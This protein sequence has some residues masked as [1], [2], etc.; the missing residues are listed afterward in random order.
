M[1]DKYDLKFLNEC[2]ANNEG[3]LTWKIR[4]LHH[5]TSQ[6]KCDAFNTRWAGKPAGNKGKRGY[7]RFT[8]AGKYYY[9]HRVV[10]LLVNGHLPDEIDHIDGNPTNNKPCNLRVAVHAENMQNKKVMQGSSKYK[11]VSWAKDKGKWRVYCTDE[12]RGKT[13]NGRNRQRYVGQSSCEIEAARMYDKAAEELY[14]EFAWL[15]KDHFEE[16]RDE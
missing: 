6:S 2:V 14:G 8:A 7:L 15:N 11:G 9:A 4:P 16:L 3:A 10:F 5:F 13:D 1:I 12:S